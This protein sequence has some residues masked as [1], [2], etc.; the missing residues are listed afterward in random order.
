MIAQFQQAGSDGS[1]PAEDIIIRNNI[2]HDSYNNDLL[3][4]N[5]VCDNILVEG[6]LFYNQSGSDEHIDV[7]GVTNVTI[8]D[9]IFFNDFEGSGRPDDK[10]PALL[11]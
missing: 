2:F 6:N 5:N 1:V 3:K 7:N 11:L 4:I 9:N 10:I 8:Q